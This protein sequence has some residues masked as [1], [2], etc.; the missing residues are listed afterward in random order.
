LKE[1]LYVNRKKMFF[2]SNAFSIN[3]LNFSNMVGILKINIY[4]M[5]LSIQ[6]KL[7]FPHNYPEAIWDFD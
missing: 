7:H 4:K 5:E 6:Q 1:V 2:F 3:Q